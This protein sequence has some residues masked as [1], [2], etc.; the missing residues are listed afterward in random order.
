ML[1]RVVW[2]SGV[3]I[4]ELIDQHCRLV[5]FLQHQTECPYKYFRE[6][7]GMFRIVFYHC[8]NKSGLVINVNFGVCIP[9]GLDKL[10]PRWRACT[11]RARKELF[12]CTKLRA[13]KSVKILLTS[14]PTL[15]KV[16]S[17]FCLWK[18]LIFCTI[19]S[20]IHNLFYLRSCCWIKLYLVFIYV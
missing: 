19:R 15:F 17:Y 7:E 16:V 18:Q 10:H 2:E 14:T 3:S 4:P 9:A 20:D 13:R 5:Q 6:Y 12:A 8:W 11:Q 1:T